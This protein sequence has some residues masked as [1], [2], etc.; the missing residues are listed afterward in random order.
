VGLG[1]LERMS[2]CWLIVGKLGIGA[3]DRLVSMMT[4]ESASVDCRM[5]RSEPGLSLG[6]GLGLGLS[7]CST[8]S[9]WELMRWVGCRNQLASDWL[10]VDWVSD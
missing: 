6:L 1:K 5:E 9:A 7:R 8:G 10:V 3:V 2:L 4:G